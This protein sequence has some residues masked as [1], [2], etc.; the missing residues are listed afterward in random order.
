MESSTGQDASGTESVTET[1]TEGSDAKSE[2][3]GSPVRYEIVFDCRDRMVGA[4]LAT[5]IVDVMGPTFPVTQGEE[6]PTWSVAIEFTG[7]AAADR[8]FA[9]DFYRQFCIEVR[10]AA[11][12]SVLVVP[13]GTQD[14]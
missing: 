2:P 13:L 1:G 5:R 3:G 10:R 7:P 9:S 6:G 4:R 14:E 8:F 11:H 12:S